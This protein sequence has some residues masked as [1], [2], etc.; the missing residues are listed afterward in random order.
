MKIHAL[1]GP[2]VQEK[3]WAPAP[4]YLLRRQRIVQLM[5]R[6]PAG[7]LLEVGCGGGTL[8]YELTDMGFACQGL[9]S[10]GAAL[11][12]ARFVND[13]RAEIHAQAG[14]EW[15]ERFDYVLAMEVLEHIED[16]A[17]ALRQWL[18]WL[19]PGGKLLLSV[20]AHAS[21]WTE[22]DVWA[23][24]YRRYEKAPLLE[25]IAATGMH[26]ERVES[27]GFPL[28]NLLLSW[29]ARVHRKALAGGGGGENRTHNNARSGID[30][31]T[32][33]RLFPLLANL[34]GRLLMRSAFTL[35][36]LTVNRD[37]G[38]GYLVLASRPASGS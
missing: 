35:Q 11:D 15:Q 32:A 12:V 23:G 16:D 18:A 8:L 6:L 9:E 21:K 17:Q 30:R 10:S 31:D 20:P 5:R 1:Y 4:G 25:L 2:V 14:Q 3:N 13:G 36:Q 33:M 7:E 28:S 27:W 29:R 38:V 37:W 24:H 22:S 19:R 34:P 26:I